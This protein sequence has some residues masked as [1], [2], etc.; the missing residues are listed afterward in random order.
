MK[1]Q[2]LNDTAERINKLLD[3]PTALATSASS[4]L[5]SILKFHETTGSLSEN[6]IKVLESMEERYKPE[7]SEKRKQWVEQYDNEKRNVARIC[8][9]Y[10]TAN[11]GQYYHDLARKVLDVPDFIPTEKQYNAMCCN[12]YACKVLESTFSEAK[13]PVGTFVSVR[14]GRYS[15]GGN[16]ELRSACAD[17][18]V[19][20]LANNHKPVVSA[21]KGSKPYRVLPVG[22]N[23]YFE[24]EE[25][26][27]KAYKKKKKSRGH[28]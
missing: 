17:K 14:G 19:L 3:G 8:A 2:K 1:V 16:Y 6:Q 7:H 4:F 18:P 11:N 25:R 13:F 23:K 9:E 5:R 20:V 15:S 22:T 21:A 10:Y 26:D 28:G 12:K 24:A 27:L